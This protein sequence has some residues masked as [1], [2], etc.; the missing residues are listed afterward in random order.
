LF[1]LVKITESEAGNTAS[2]FLFPEETVCFQTQSADFRTFARG[3]V[4]N[5]NKD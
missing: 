3:N 1:L 4:A 5:G 2:D